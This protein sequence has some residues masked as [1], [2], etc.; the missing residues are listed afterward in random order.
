MDSFQ[1]VR[2]DPNLVNEQRI[3]K[4]I[5]ERYF[6]SEKTLLDLAEKHGVSA[7]STLLQSNGCSYV[8]LATGTIG[9]TQ[10]Y[11]PFIGALPNP[12]RYWENLAEK[13]G[14]PRLNLL[15]EDR[16]AGVREIYGLLAHNPVGRDFSESSQKLG[17]I[18]FCVPSADAKEWVVELSMEEIIASYTTEAK[19]NVRRLPTLRAPKRKE[20]DKSS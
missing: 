6:R 5:Q 15:E 4:L 20:I 13:T 18:Q 16:L 14:I 9:L 10:S 11:V 1:Q 19:S 17:M 12:A 2:N 7:S 3:H 8:Y